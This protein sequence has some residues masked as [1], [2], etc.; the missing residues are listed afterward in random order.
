MMPRTRLWK[1]LVNSG[2]ELQLYS[3][4]NITGGTDAQGEVNVRMVGSE[5]RVVS[6]HGSDPDIIVASVK[7]YV[8][9]LNKLLAPGKRIH[10]QAAAI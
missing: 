6:G 8:S 9:G 1:T 4:N 7:A 3:V 10:P 2:C 5:G